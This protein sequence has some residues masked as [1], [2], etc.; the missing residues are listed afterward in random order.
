MVLVTA[1]REWEILQI[2]VVCLIC[3]AHAAV[4]AAEVVEGLG[5]LVVQEEVTPGLCCYSTLPAMRLR[6][7]LD[8]SFC[9]SEGRSILERN[10]GMPVNSARTLSFQGGRMAVPATR[11]PYINTVEVHGKVCNAVAIS[12]THILTKASCIGAAAGTN[13]D[14]GA[15]KGG[16]GSVWTPAQLGLHSKQVHIHPNWT[17][18]TSDQH[19]AA[20]LTLGKPIRDQ[21][22][23]LADPT[24]C[25]VEHLPAHTVWP[26]GGGGYLVSSYTACADPWCCATTGLVNGT[27]A[28]QP[29]GTCDLP[30]GILVLLESPSAS[31]APHG[32]GHT[33]HATIESGS[34]D[35]DLLVGIYALPDVAL[36][37]ET[38]EEITWIA[39]IRSWIDEIIL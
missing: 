20:I 31:T 13:F 7:L 35:L 10:D 38:A 18:A 3:M 32:C 37:S 12:K 23:V 1:T 25:L 24:F 22:V 26:W 6:A 33:S 17:G 8:A 15:W 16:V 11:F 14:P 27:S 39:T 29:N 5:S 2:L 19:D 30:G 28:N 21:P 34:P 4:L 9:Q 36:D